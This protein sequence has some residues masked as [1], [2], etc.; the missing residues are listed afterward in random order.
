MAET[1]A[2][3]SRKR[4]ANA[5]HVGNRR[6]GL[7]HQVFFVVT[8]D[9]RLG[10]EGGLVGQFAGDVLDRAADGI[11]AV[12]RALRAAQHFDAFEVVD[13]GQRALRAGH[14]DVVEV[15][16]DALLVAGDRILL[17][18]AADEGGQRGVGAA[19]A[20]QRRAWNDF[21]Q[22]RNVGYRL[23]FQ[24]GAGDR[25]H[26]ARH[27]LDQFVA[28]ARGD[29]DLVDFPDGAFGRFGGGLR[30]CRSPRYGG[31]RHDGRDRTTQ[32][33]LLFARHTH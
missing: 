29:D 14:V 31:N 18:D 6:A 10:V 17:A 4:A 32:H 26:R 25:A 28:A 20:F 7:E 9:R 27:V 11:F 5:Q 8:A 23:L 1:V 22:R 13:V 12:Q 15:D 33:R 2:V 21:G 19:R 16:A 24:F 3:K 30:V